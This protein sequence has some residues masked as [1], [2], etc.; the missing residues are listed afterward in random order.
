MK[1]LAVYFPDKESPIEKLL[2]VVLCLCLW[3]CV[4]VVNVLDIEVSPRERRW[5][6][7]GQ[8]NKAAKEA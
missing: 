2:V 4:C 8:V 3:D 6:F 7:S 1:S 5:D